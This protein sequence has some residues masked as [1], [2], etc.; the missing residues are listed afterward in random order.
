MNLFMKKFV[1]LTFFLVALH[2]TGQILSI[3]PPFPTS[4]DTISIVYDA[5]K[6]NGA[7]SGVSPIYAHTGLIT[8]TSSSPTNW[9]FVQGVWGQPTPSVLM[10]D[11]GNDK[12]Q[13]DYHIPSFY[14]FPVMTTNVMELAFVFRDAAGNNVGRASDGSDIYYTIYQSSVGLLGRFITPD[15]NLIVD[16]GD[17][18]EIHGAANGN[19]MFSLYDNGILIASDSMLNSDHFYYD[20]I[21]S[22]GGNHLL[23]L[24]IDNGGSQA[25]VRDTTFYFSN[26]SI[27]YV[28]PPLGLIDGIN[29]VNDS[30]VT[31]ILNAPNKSFVYVLGDFN[32]F[33]PDSSFFMNKSLDG[34]RFWLT[35]NLSPNTRY[36]YQYWIDGELKLADPYS[37]LIL[38]PANDPG[39]PNTTYP[40]PHPYPTGLTTGHCTL[41]HP[42]KQKYA[43]K[44]TNFQA[45]DKSNLII[46]ELLIRDFASGADRNYQMVIDTLDYLVRLGINAIELMPNNEFENN[47][48]W[49]YNPSYH[50]ALDKYYGTQEKYKELIDSC[51]S[52]GIA[53]IMDFVFNHAFGQSPLVKMYWDASANRPSAD[54]PWF[55]SSCPHPPYCWGYDF[56]HTSISTQD[57][58]DR[59]NMFWIQEYNIDGIRFDFTKGFTNNSN[60]GW[61]IQRQVLLKRMADTIWTVNPD[62]Y[63]ILEHWGDNN[64]E[65]ILSDYGMMLWGNTTYNYRQAAMGFTNSSNFSNA[66]YKNRGWN[67][68]HLIS[69]MESHDEER[70]MYDVNTLG[71]NS[72]PNLYNVRD[73][74]VGL[75]RAELVSAFNFLI[76]GPK[77]LYMFSELGYDISIN[78]PCRICNKPALW[79]YQ[80][81]PERKRLYDITS[82][83]INLRKNHPSTFNTK[84]FYYSLTSRTKRLILHDSV[85]N[86][87]VIGNFDIWYRNVVPNFP[88]VGVWYDYF[89]SDS[90]IVTDQY[91]S[92]TLAPGEYRVYTD[93][94]LN[95]PNVNLSDKEYQDIREEIIFYPNPANDFILID[96]PSFDKIGEM[97]FQIT[98]MLGRILIQSSIK[99]YGFDQVKK[100][101]VSQLDPGLYQIQI[102]LEGKKFNGS[103]I[104]E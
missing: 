65:K 49:G 104:I 7:L 29:Y 98:D 81:I 10:T 45:P 82:A 2:S 74:N 36:A 55:N 22:S 62:L 35:L 41:I 84:D 57:F 6:G 69:Y 59:V 58:M 34:E 85:M 30:T 17:T 20:L 79:N 80:Q 46:Y 96:F 19:A 76:P 56:D 70:L 71:N 28:N 13:I 73:I 60:S 40:N 86:A 26:P 9:K 42:G 100:I 24:I 11:L 66:V 51:H 33:L 78:N 68:P 21:V 92:L 63:V 54:N 12:H 99:N 90:L 15:E 64:E 93:M 18:I 48:S 83:L 75:Q 23:E 4:Q 3:D 27:S 52:R 47:E 43:W 89:S 87:N 39:I 77:M 1:L 44:N 38:D 31:L 50:M 94:K 101:N 8:S 102:S 91:M 32:N 67:D 25:P 95:Q 103:I 16:P 61:D 97:N 53:V 14:G 5:T 37:E 72:Q 88:H